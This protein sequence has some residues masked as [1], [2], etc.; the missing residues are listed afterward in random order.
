MNV[1]DKTELFK[2]IIHK[3]GGQCSLDC[4]T[5]AGRELMILEDGE[6]SWFRIDGKEISVHLPAFGICGEYSKG[7]PC[8]NDNCQKIHLC[9]DVILESCEKGTKCKLFHRFTN[10]HNTKVIRRF[11]GLTE[12]DVLLYIKLTLKQSEKPKSERKETPKRT[13]SRS[14]RRSQQKLWKI[15]TNRDVRED[16]INWASEKKT[17]TETAHS[18]NAGNIKTVE[19]NELADTDQTIPKEVLNSVDEPLPNVSGNQVEIDKLEAISKHGTTE[20]RSAVQDSQPRKKSEYIT[21]SIFGNRSTI[22]GEKNEDIRRLTA[23]KFLLKQD[24]GVS[25]FNKFVEGIGFGNREAALRWINSNAGLK[26]CKLFQ[27]SGQTDALVMTYVPYLELCIDYGGSKGCTTEQCSKIHICREFLEG[28]CIKEI[29]HLTHSITHL[30]SMKALALAGVESL[31]IAEILQ[32]VQFSL[33]QICVDYSTEEGCTNLDCAKFH[34]CAEFAKGRCIFGGDC[35]YEHNFSSF[36]NRALVAF[37]GKEERFLLESSIIPGYQQL[38]SSPQSFRTLPAI[39]KMLSAKEAV[40]CGT[41]PLELGIEC[42]TRINTGVASATV[43]KDSD[44]LPESFKPTCVTS[45]F[46]DPFHTFG[47]KQNKSQFNSLNDLTYAATASSTNSTEH[48]VSPSE[49]SDKSIL[50]QVVN[51]LLQSPD[52]CS[53][54]A[55]IHKFL[56]KDFSTSMDLL[57]WLTGP[58]G[59]TICVTQSATTP[60]ETTVALLIRNFQLCFDYCSKAGCKATSCPFLHICRNYIKDACIYKHCKFSHDPIDSHNQSIVGKYCAAFD[61]MEDIRVAIRQSIPK[62]CEGFNST[63]GCQNPICTRFHICANFVQKMCP[64]HECKKIHTLQTPHNMRLLSTMG[65]KENV[66]FKMLLV[67]FSTG[68]TQHRCSQGLKSHNLAS[69]HNQNLPAIHERN[70]G[71][72]HKML[73]VTQNW[74]SENMKTSLKSHPNNE[75]YNLE[76]IC[77]KEFLPEMLQ[78]NNG[79]CSMKQFQATFPVVLTTKESLE[80]INKP[81]VQKYMTAFNMDSEVMMMAK[82]KGLKICF[83]YHGIQGCLNNHCSFLHLCKQF[84]VGSCSRSEQC[85]YSHDVKNTHN[86]RVLHD[87]GLTREL[88]ESLILKLIQNSLPTICQAYNSKTG[89]MDRLCHRFHICVYHVLRSCLRSDIC[90]YGHSFE[91]PHNKK[92]LELYQCNSNSIKGKVIAEKYSPLLSG[93]YNKAARH[94]SHLIAITI[95]IQ[96]STHLH[97]CTPKL[98]KT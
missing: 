67:T 7:M 25:G 49:S 65:F 73:L 13:R 78:N 55:H 16:F 48:F 18:D 41:K 24:R 79:Y 45:G 4:I 5:D 66:A 50:R 72:M 91:T 96:D 40:T 38:L 69:A 47:H 58:I 76:D 94:N 54:L 9:P 71:T 21:T 12:D 80:L 14:R 63:K 75:E 60:H 86:L 6:A 95:L 35:S 19:Q 90:S 34:I 88:P 44:L 92:L 31:R 56:N 3:F 83:A 59:K 43:I 87:V 11:P 62:V 70:E 36:L 46:E 15:S 23:I 20:S 84:V 77:L 51:C 61:S 52:G 68:D 29:C 53:S 26:V 10:A 17:N 32:A 39:P 33:P 89:C 28:T 8:N 42:L 22:L 2:T 1:W 74:G 37:Y 27:L 30:M 82:V 81:M 57:A 85:K 98:T 64:F 93:K 97:N